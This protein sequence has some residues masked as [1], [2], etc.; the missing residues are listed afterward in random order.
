MKLPNTWEDYTSQYLEIAENLIKHNPIN[1]D[2]IIPTMYIAR[3]YIELRTKM[4]A[5]IATVISGGQAQDVQG[6]NLKTLWTK[7]SNLIIEMLKKNSL[8]TPNIQIQLQAIEKFIEKRTN[9]D[10]NSMA[11]RYPF[12]LDGVAYDLS[13]NI[14]LFIKEWN[15]C[16]DALEYIY[17]Q[18]TTDIQKGTI[19]LT[20]NQKDSLRNNGIII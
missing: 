6:H 13:E 16:T 5:K 9:W 15:N 3:H 8:Y 19:P 10:S 18:L 17:K 20:D 2:L 11:L 4:I 12:D 1:T 7:S 14:P